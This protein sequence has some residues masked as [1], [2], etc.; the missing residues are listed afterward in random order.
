VLE[1]LSIREAGQL[2]L[3]LG[4]GTTEVRRIQQARAALE[5]YADSMGRPLCEFVLASFVE[6][7]ELLDWDK[8]WDQVVDTSNPPFFK[9][10]V[11]GKLNAC[12]NCVETGLDTD[13][14]FSLR[15]L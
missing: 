9:W 15:E 4:K 8:T 3:T 5:R 14:I 2:L 12:V 10:W 11:G 7:A 1:R 13:R 6:Y